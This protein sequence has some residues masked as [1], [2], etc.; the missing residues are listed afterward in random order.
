[1]V[2]EMARGWHGNMGDG[3]VDVVGI[4]DPKSDP[5]LVDERFE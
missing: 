1:V 2:W 5:E 3:W 4:V